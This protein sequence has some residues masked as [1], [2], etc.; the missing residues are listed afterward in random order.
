MVVRII[1]DHP[2]YIPSYVLEVPQQLLPQV[3]EIREWLRRQSEHTTFYPPWPDS[4]AP[5]LLYFQ[6]ESFA[7]AFI[8]KWG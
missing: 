3:D 2:D 6:N 4:A 7:T 1:D 8:L 5:G